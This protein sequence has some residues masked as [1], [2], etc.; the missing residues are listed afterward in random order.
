VPGYELRLVD[1]T[2]SDVAAGEP[3]ELEVRGES[4][5]L[6]YWEEHERSKQTF[7]GDLV[8]TGDLFAED[9]DGF[10]YYRGRA[11]SLLK[12]GGIWVAPLEIEQCLQEHPD[13]AECAVVGRAQEGLVVPVATVVRE[14][15]GAQLSAE[16]VIEHA[17][18]HLSPH[19]APRVVEFI[20]ELPKT[21]SGKVDRT[22]LQTP[23]AEASA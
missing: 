13:V 3:G 6:C 20:A 2:G 11:D 1:D 19:K 10:L 5:A 22:A 15:T 4:A 14:H 9:A 12:V 16:D 8:R 23:T 21:A 18:A 17:R 7:A